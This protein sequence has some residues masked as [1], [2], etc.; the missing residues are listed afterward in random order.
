MK[1]DKRIPQHKVGVRILIDQ[2][3]ENIFPT[4]RSMLEKIED[5][6]KEVQEV[7]LEAGQ[8]TYQDYLMYDNVFGIFGQRG[9]G[10]SS[11]IFTIRDNI[12]NSAKGDYALPIIMPDIIV[13]PEGIMGWLLAMLGDSIKDLKV[14]L[15]IKDEDYNSI[16]AQCKVKNKVSAIQELEMLYNELC[17][18]AFSVK[19]SPGCSGDYFDSISDFTGQSRDEYNVT[20]LFVEFWNTFVKVLKELSN[21]KAPLIYVI[22]DDVDLSPHRVEEMVSTI[23]RYLSHPNV[24]TIVTA[25]EDELTKVLEKIYKE[26]MKVN[27]EICSFDEE[28][29]IAN[30]AKA[31]LDK[32]F[33]PSNRYY[34]QLFDSVEKKATFIEKDKDSLQRLLENKIELYIKNTNQTN[35]Y[36]VDF[37]HYEGKF[38]SFYLKIF[39][40]T[41]RQITNGYFTIEETIDNLTRIANSYNSD[42]VEIRHRLQ[43]KIY[44][45]IR[46]F[47][48]NMINSNP[49]MAFTKRSEEMEKVC[50]NLFIFDY[51]GL[52]LY[53]NYGYLIKWYNAELEKAD[54]QLKDNLYIRNERAIRK[55]VIDELYQNKLL[56]IR[57]SLA[58]TTLCGFALCFFT[59]SLLEILDRSKASLVKNRNAIHGYMELI[60]FIEIISEPKVKLIK[61][62]DNVSQLLYTYEVAFEHLVDIINFNMMEYSCVYRYFTAVKG[63]G[64]IP[65]ENK[66]GIATNKIMR[67]MQS[68]PVW[69]KSM[70]QMTFMYFGRY[71]LVN[72]QLLPNGTIQNLVMLNCGYINSVE[73][74]LQYVIDEVIK[75][76]NILQTA[77]EYIV[78]WKKLRKRKK[79]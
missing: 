27:D 36:S 61:A 53:V 9:S 38:L 2:Q 69:F 50:D 31:Y 72:R 78:H 51:N 52:P 24:I 7:S 21:K 11:T 42:S 46:R 66:Q 19:Y 29:R 10:K 59:E 3:V 37:L 30:S 60:K 14:K 39:G 77:D 62:V 58:E 25:D 65:N 64:I 76:G 55:S 28:E 70:V 34:L 68:D 48:R 1:K 13:M 67:L 20:R 41:A 18:K 45:V 47:I 4:Y 54:K 40:V 22:F 32:L 17:E 16:F 15:G 6:R 56:E 73:G 33:P 35:E 12:I 8:E 75:T 79:K 57:T 63:E 5:Y 43:T 44:Y 71:Y 49:N 74:K 26:K 23:M